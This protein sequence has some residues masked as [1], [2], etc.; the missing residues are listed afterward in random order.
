MW[1]LQR[2]YAAISHALGPR[3]PLVGETIT[4]EGYLRW[5]TQAGG[6]PVDLCQCPECAAVGAYD[7]LFGLVV[8]PGLQFADT[9]RL[10]WMPGKARECIF[11]GHSLGV[12]G[13]W[14]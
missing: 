7:W 2:L 1:L 11:C 13:G 4:D 10:Q 3:L 9:V 6:M 12:W 14:P 5:V 8:V